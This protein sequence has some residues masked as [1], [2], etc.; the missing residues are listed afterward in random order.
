MQ[1]SGYSIL[2]HR[3]VKGFTMPCLFASVRPELVIGW[4]NELPSRINSM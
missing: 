1:N 4:N 2:Q 3:T